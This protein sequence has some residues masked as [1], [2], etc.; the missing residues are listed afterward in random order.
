LG[1][2]EQGKNCAVRIFEG[3]QGKRTLGG[4]GYVQKGRVGKGG[5]KERGKTPGI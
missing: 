5:R 2:T 1:K 4:L 3:E